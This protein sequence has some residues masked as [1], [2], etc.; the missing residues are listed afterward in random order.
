MRLLVR[1][2]DRVVPALIV[3]TGVTVLAAGLLTYTAGPA[4]ANPLRVSPSPG[5]VA[6][7]PSAGPTGGQASAEPRSPAP[8]RTPKPS[9]VPQSVLS[10]RVT[11][12]SLRI[13]LPV[14]A[15]DAVVAGNQGGYPLCDVAQYLVPYRH[16]NRDGITYIYAHARAGMF[17]P[18]LEASER[19]NG[20]E[21]IGGLVQ[22]YTNEPRVYLFE[23][24]RVRRHATRLPSESA[25]RPGERL[26]YLQTSEGPYGTVPKLQVVARLLGSRPARA[27]EAMP[28]PRPR[29]C[30]P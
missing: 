16:P 6:A 13:D 10:T 15:G 9:R 30:P 2:I 5:S 27:A 7:G 12:P 8:T 26:L 18:L 1:T 4:P 19:R 29:A 23:I 24:F 14:I 28:R 20:A 25:L 3:A 21:L 17:L 22:V 11:V